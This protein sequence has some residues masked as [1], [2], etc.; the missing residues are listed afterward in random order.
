MAKGHVRF[1]LG[2]GF[3]FAAA[4]SAGGADGELEATATPD[5][6]RRDAGSLAD[7]GGGGP[8]PALDSSAPVI[9]SSAPVI[10]SSAPVIDS[11]APVIDS[12]APAIDAGAA[13]V[14]SGR[15]DSGAPAVD[16]GAPVAD[17]GPRVCAP[18][19]TTPAFT[20]GIAWPAAA[21]WNQNRCTAATVQGFLD[22]CLGVNSTLATCNAWRSAN[23]NCSACLLTSRTAATVGPFLTSTA[24]TPANDNPP[25]LDPEWVQGM[26]SSCMN[27]FRAGCGPAYFSFSNCL[28][29]ACNTTAAGNCATATS[30]QVEL[31]EDNAIGTS[32]APGA[33]WNVGLAALNPTTGTCRGVF[34]ADAGTAVSGN[35]CFARGAARGEDTTTQA[36]VDAFLKRVALYFCGP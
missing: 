18:P 28:G 35:D 9:D 24:V 22:A 8:G 5:A 14:D 6:G 23:A 12:S 29:A 15:L 17:A 30:A 21:N 13:P 26:L 36:G 27:H 20:P 3:A 1:I 34:P 2:V 33:C 31:C 7:T 19:A 25:G 4:C 10:D 16:S 11:S 32:L